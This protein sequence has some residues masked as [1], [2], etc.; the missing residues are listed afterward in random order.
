LKRALRN[1]GNLLGNCLYDKSY[2]QEV[3]KIKVAPVRSLSIIPFFATDRSPFKKISPNLTK[4]NCT[5]VLNSK[6]R[7]QT[8]HPPPHRPPKQHPP[9]ATVLGLIIHRIQAFLVPKLNY[10]TRVSHQSLVTCGPKSDPQYLPTI[11]APLPR[12]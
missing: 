11:P 7:N 3:V 6:S 5:V 12:Q 8:S 1:F 2:T 4:V 9:L 10:I